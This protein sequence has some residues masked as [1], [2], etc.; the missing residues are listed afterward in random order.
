M[1]RRSCLAA[2]S[3]ARGFG[4]LVFFAIL[5]TILPSPL[6]ALGVGAAIGRSMGLPVRAVVSSGLFWILLMS[7][8]DILLPL[9]AGFVFLRC[10]LMGRPFIEQATFH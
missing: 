5:L 9:L 10:C 4:R 1:G 6:V 7:M 2:F 8:G 3:A